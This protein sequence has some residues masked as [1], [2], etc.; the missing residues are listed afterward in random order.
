MR[1]AA[2][3]LVVSLP[4]I[5]GAMNTT[6]ED[7][8]VHNAERGRYTSMYAASYPFLCLPPHVTCFRNHTPGGGGLSALQSGGAG[9]YVPPSRRAGASSSSAGESLSTRNDRDDSCTLRVSNISEDA[10]EQDLRE[11]FGAFGGVQ[12]VFLAK[13]R[14]TQLSRGFAFVSYY[15]RS[16]AE[17]AME[18]LQGYGYDHLILRLEWARPSNRD[19]GSENVMRFA[20]GYGKALPQGTGGKR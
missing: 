1:V 15:E 8:R 9:K 4:L 12:R 11:L 7:R 5:D 18:K 19:A 17:K 3:R 16:D 13:D 20:S 14:E 2:A 6:A 10:N